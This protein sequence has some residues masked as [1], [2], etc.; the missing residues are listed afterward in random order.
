[1]LSAEAG[2]ASPNPPEGQ[3]P[4]L[5]GLGLRGQTP[6][7]TLVAQ[8]RSQHLATHPPVS[9]S[10]EPS[11]TWPTWRSHTPCTNV[12]KALPPASKPEA[13]RRSPHLKPLQSGGLGFTPGTARGGPGRPGS[14]AAPSRFPGLGR[15]R[16][17][18]GV[19]APAPHGG[20][21]QEALG[22]ARGLG[23]AA[24]VGCV[25]AWVALRGPGEGS[26]CAGQWGARPSEGRGP[27]AG[28][29]PQPGPSPP[30]STPRS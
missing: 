5:G 17:E 3:G 26:C 27:G 2:R 16:P 21:A 30:P 12:R 15:L 24:L 20:P 11:G 28:A 13:P 14:L 6:L 18:M 29:R 8:S 25:G 7:H 9:V 10:H 22:P 23:A 1:M 19:V 4:W